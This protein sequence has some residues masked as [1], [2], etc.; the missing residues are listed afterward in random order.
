[1]PAIG[2][3]QVILW[4]CER[5]ACPQA[6]ERSLQMLL[7]RYGIALQRLVAGKSILVNTLLSKSCPF[8]TTHPS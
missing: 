6:S 5:F 7:G 4:C 2:C 8:R 1:M 3:A